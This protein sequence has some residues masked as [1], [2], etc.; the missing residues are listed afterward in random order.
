[1]AVLFIFIGRM[2]VLRQLLL[3][4]T[5]LTRVGVITKEALRPGDNTRFL[6]AP[7]RGGGSR[8]SQWQLFLIY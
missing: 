5:T 2:I 1:M 6:P 4:L 7:R 8:P 3:M